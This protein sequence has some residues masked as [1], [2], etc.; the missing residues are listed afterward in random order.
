[1]ATFNKLA[2]APGVGQPNIRPP[3]TAGIAMPTVG[4]PDAD[5]LPSP[6]DTPPTASDAKQAIT[7]HTSSVIYNTKHAAAHQQ[8]A[9]KHAGKLMELLQK[10]PGFAEHAKKVK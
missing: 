10:M 4:E 6:S 1:M 3:L 7:H 5:D 9:G 2:P 8:E